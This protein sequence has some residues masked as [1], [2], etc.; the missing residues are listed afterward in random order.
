MNTRKPIVERFDSKKHYESMR[1]WMQQRGFSAPPVDILPEDGFVVDDTAMGFLYTTTSGKMS[2]AEWI[3]S[4]S[5]KS[6]EDRANA[7]DSLMCLLIN[8]AKAKGMIAV[9]SYSKM[10]AFSVI[11]ERNGFFSTD[12]GMKHY[13]NVVQKHPDFEE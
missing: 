4:N 12:E 6:K 1:A 8:F 7:L 3:T 11:L 9:F 2:F 5:E 10:D 13:I